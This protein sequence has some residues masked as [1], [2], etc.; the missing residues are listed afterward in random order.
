[1]FAC[2][3]DFAVFSS[4]FFVSFFLCQMSRDEFAS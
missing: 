1:M 2:K 4:L 3:V